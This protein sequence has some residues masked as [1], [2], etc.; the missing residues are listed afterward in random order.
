VITVL[1][2]LVRV[3][4]VVLL[5]AS[6]GAYALP[7]SQLLGVVVSGGLGARAA[8]AALDRR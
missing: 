1:A 4:A 5:A 3:A 2:S 6:I 8:A 7:V